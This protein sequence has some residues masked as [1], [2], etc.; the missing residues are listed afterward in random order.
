MEIKPRL[1]ELL[2]MI[3]EEE[4]TYAASLSEAYGAKTGTLED[5][6]PKD[7]LVHLA[8]SHQEMVK[9]VQAS[10]RGETIPEDE[11]YQGINDRIF[12]DHKDDPW[13]QVVDWLAQAN[14]EMI[15]HCRLFT[16]QQLKSKDFLSHQ[17][18]RP[19]WRAIAGNGGMH[20]LAH[21]AQLYA[22]QADATSSTRM[23]ERAASLMAALD[24]SP[25]WIGTVQY[26]LAC[27]Y[28]LCGEKEKA[29]PLL[30]EAFQLSPRLIEWSK[31]DHD[32]DSLRELP[33]FQAFFTRTTETQSS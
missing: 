22:L 14:R 16:E 21:L 18:D 30:V 3:G 23:Q 5:W 11:H 25:D 13:S 7:V 6:A 27:H 12:Q 32:L 17:G 19:L 1:M 2:N 10:L 8:F 9:Y 4:Q 26:N 20:P 15:E 33:E 24:D 31:D 29:I 28:A